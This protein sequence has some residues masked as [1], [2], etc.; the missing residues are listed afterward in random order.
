MSTMLWRAFDKTVL[1]S[2]RHRNTKEER[3]TPPHFIR[4]IIE[5]HATVSRSRLA[6]LHTPPRLE[7]P[8]VPVSTTPFAACRASI[9]CAELTDF[10]GQ[11]VNDDSFATTYWTR[12]GSRS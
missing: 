8:I 1:G 5:P 3:C 9:L 11:E 4:M 10:Q 6:I 12:N 7:A 2:Q